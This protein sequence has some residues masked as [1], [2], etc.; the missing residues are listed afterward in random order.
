MVM[1]RLPQAE[2]RKN[3]HYHHNQTDQIN[4]T[5]HDVSSST[6][7]A[8][9][10]GVTTKVPPPAPVSQFQLPGKTTVGMK[11]TSGGRADVRRSNNNSEALIV[12]IRFDVL[13][14]MSGEPR[15]GLEPIC[16]R[17]GATEGLSAT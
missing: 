8:N 9:K 5:V 6:G 2:E 16:C 13:G 12:P 3:R 7:M 4:Q 15:Y 10:L 14:E 11:Q 17:T 1:A